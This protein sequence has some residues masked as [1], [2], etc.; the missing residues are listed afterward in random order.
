[1]IRVILQG[2]SGNNLFQYAAGRALADRHGTELILDGSWADTLHARQFEHLLRLPVRAR[3][4][5]RFTLAKRSLRKAFHL[6]PASLHHGPVFYDS[7][8][9]PDPAFHQFPDHCLLIGFFQ[10]PFYFKTIEPQLREELDFKDLPLPKES[11]IFEENLRS[12]TTV[13]LHVRRGDYVHLTSTQCLAPDYHARAIQ[14]F[15]NRDS[16]VRF[17]VFSDDIDWCRNQFKEPDFLF[18]DLPASRPDPLHD[19]RLMAACHH[20]V[21]VNSS[22][23]WWGAWL[24]PSADK[25]VVAPSMWMT[26]LPSTS[27]LFPDWITI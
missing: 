11:L 19:M 7:S 10:S 13:S 1:M 2:R 20:H 4:E 27:L 5:R 8:P 16:N 21:I 9:T 15:R 24:N 14:H 23:S 25:V 12:Q 3:Y 6:S 22:Y 17:C 26:D 18:C